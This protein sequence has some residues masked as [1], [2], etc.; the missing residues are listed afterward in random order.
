M[1]Y[2]DAHQDLSVQVHPDDAKGR[3][4]AGDSGKTETWVILEA[5]PGSSIYAG[6]QQGVSR[7]EFAAAIRSGGVEP[8]L[9]RVEP[10]AGDCILIE[11]GTVHAIGAGVLLAEIQQTSDATFRVYDWGR[12]GP[13]GKP[14]TLHIEQA[15]ESIDFDRGPVKPIDTTRRGTCLAEASASSSRARLISLSNDSTSRSRRRSGD[16][17]GSRS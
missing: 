13:D 3:R 9:H 6:L 5:E 17:I 4:L 15:L 14:R 11:S 7:S 16:P 1:K 8:L 2:I 10:K 12:V